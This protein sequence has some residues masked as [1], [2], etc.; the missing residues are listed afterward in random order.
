MEV[1]DWLGRDRKCTTTQRSIN[2]MHNRLSVRISVATGNR[3]SNGEDLQA[4]IPQIQKMHV[5]LL[6]ILFLD[7]ISWESHRECD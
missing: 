3:V 4:P 1:G 2:S 6:P 7:V 5:D